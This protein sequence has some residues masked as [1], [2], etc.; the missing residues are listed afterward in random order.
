[1]TIRNA[2]VALAGATLAAM[3]AGPAHAGKLYAVSAQYEPSN[4]VLYRYQVDGPGDHRYE[5]NADGEADEPELTQPIGQWPENSPAALAFSPWKEMFVFDR[6]PGGNG[7]A[8]GSIF[9]FLD[10]DGPAPAANGRIV[11][12][13]PEFTFS[14]PHWGAFRGNELFL[15]QRYGTVERFLVDPAGP[16][17]YNGQIQVLSGDGTRGVQVTPWGEV[18]V[19]QLGSPPVLRYRIEPDGTATPNG[20]IDCGAAGPHDLVFGPTGELFIA[21]GGYQGSIVRVTFDQDRNPSCTGA[22]TDPRLYATIG[23]SVA[24]W[25]ELFVSSH[26]ANQITRWLPDATGFTYNGAIYTPVGPVVA[27][28]GDVEYFD[29]AP[30]EYLTVRSGSSAAVRVDDL[31]RQRDTANASTHQV[32]QDGAF[33]D[34]VTEDAYLIPTYRPHWPLIPGTSW[35]SWWPDPYSPGMGPWE[36]FFTYE[37]SFDLPPSTEVALRL[38]FASD[39]WS[40]VYLNGHRIVDQTTPV[41]AYYRQGVPLPEGFCTY[42]GSAQNCTTTVVVSDPS[43]FVPGRNV[44][45]FEQHEPDGA[46]GLGYLATVSYVPDPVPPVITITSPQGGAAYLLRQPVLASWTATDA[47]SGIASATGTAASGA[48]IDT[49][50]VGTKTFEVTAVDVAG[51]GASQAVT[52]DVRYVFGGL[53]QPLAGTTT[54]TF[55]RGDTVQVR[56]QLFDFARA[57]V[58]SAQAHLFVAPVVG[59]AV[60]PEAPAVPATRN[61]VGNLFRFDARDRRYEYGMSTSW[62]APGTWQLRIAL[63]DGTSQLKRITIRR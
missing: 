8:G 43:L 48:A 15:A 44:L 59:G 42:G 38:E 37:S 11:S 60:G 51:N 32:Y 52:Y 25:G 3:P 49:A 13:P 10:P 40:D 24:P 22:F 9:R 31:G 50:T 36:Q 20:A 28:L 29:A 27:G 39:D 16:V 57:V 35:I 18:L 45:R 34:W 62:L 63:D 33:G 19:M 58:G 17:A 53:Q 56:F 41:F 6:G 23:I 12:S 54:P 30:R 7:G 4:A 26:L 46:G 1:M 5:L 2:L 21:S 61:N 14:T 47:G 55:R